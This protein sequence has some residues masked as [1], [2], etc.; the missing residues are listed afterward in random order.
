[1]IHGRGKSLVTYSRPDG[2]PCL[3][4]ALIFLRQRSRKI[5][6][7]FAFFVASPVHCNVYASAEQPSDEN[8]ESASELGE[9]EPCVSPYNI[10]KFIMLFVQTIGPGLFVLFDMFEG[11]TQN[12]HLT[13]S[14]A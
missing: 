13:C 2:Q 11:L 4:L 12:Q 5:Q 8:D 10:F 9:V 14:K 6:Y 7:Q 3:L 1:M